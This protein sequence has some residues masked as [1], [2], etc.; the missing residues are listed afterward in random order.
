MCLNKNSDLAE[1]G[2]DDFSCGLEYLMIN[3]DQITQALAVHAAWK[4]RLRRI[5]ECG[6]SELSREQ[7]Q[8]DNRCDF[9]KWLYSLSEAEKQRDIWATVRSAHAEFHK[10]AAL[11]L[12]LALKGS[13]TEALAA[14]A[15]NSRYGQTSGN[16]V[17]LLTQWVGPSLETDDKAR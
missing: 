8:A 12:D 17:I 2:Y 14:L 4:S 10:E 13:R 7:V 1:D 6:S 5:I 9:G 3:G 15:P 16:L 11:I